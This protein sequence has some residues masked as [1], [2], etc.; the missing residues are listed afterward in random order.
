MIIILI[1]HHTPNLITR[2]PEYRSV[3]AAP[4]APATAVAAT[5]AG[6][7][8]QP[9]VPLVWQGAGSRTAR[10]A[11]EANVCVHEGGNGREMGCA[12]FASC[13]CTANVHMTRHKRW[14]VHAGVEP[15]VC[16][17]RCIGLPG[18]CISTPSPPP[19]HSAGTHIRCRL[20]NALTGAACAHAD[21]QGCQDGAL[22]PPPPIFHTAGAHIYAA[23]C[24]THCE[25]TCTQTHRRTC[26][27]TKPARTY[28]R[29][30]MHTP[31]QQRHLA[32]LPSRI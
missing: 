28:T 2:P 8:T 4:V 27:P 25:D 18:W 7:P 5:P 11:A 16:T 14:A 24:R 30:H 26:A 9:P 17:C 3:A 1:P 6:A 12:L 13:R 29:T 15:S 10:D 31:N 19:P 22:V 21:A 32:L 23:G 20:Q